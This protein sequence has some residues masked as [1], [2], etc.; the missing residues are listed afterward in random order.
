MTL[1]AVD[2]ANLSENDLQVGPFFQG[3]P[4]RGSGKC[5]QFLKR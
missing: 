2:A 3:F 5:P 4:K 1:Q